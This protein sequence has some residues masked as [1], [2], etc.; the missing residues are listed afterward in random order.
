MFMQCKKGI[1]RRAKDGDIDDEKQPKEQGLGG[2]S[3]G[4]NL[5]GPPGEI[6]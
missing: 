3:Q 1:K 4:V 2:Q 6:N 5:S